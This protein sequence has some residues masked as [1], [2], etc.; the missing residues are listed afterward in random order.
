MTMAKGID[1]V[2]YSQISK[3]SIS[4]SIISSVTMMARGPKN[5]HMILMIFHKS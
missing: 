5:E 2:K 1:V 3:R 4:E